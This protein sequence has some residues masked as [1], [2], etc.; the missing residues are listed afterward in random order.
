MGDF[1]NGITCFIKRGLGE[2]QYHGSPRPVFITLRRLNPR[3]GW[4]RCKTT[5]AQEV[6][7]QEP[8]FCAHIPISEGLHLIA[9]KIFC[10][11]WSRFWVLM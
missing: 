8:S 9:V 2:K 3:L 6:E 1:R 4:D 11:C 7:K 10:S 5:S